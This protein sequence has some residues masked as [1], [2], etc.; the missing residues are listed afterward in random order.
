[1]R[2]QQNAVSARKSLLQLRRDNVANTACANSEPIAPAANATNVEEL[3]IRVPIE[4]CS[5]PMHLQCAI[6]WLGTATGLNS[7]R[8]TLIP[9]G[10]PICRR[11]FFNFAPDARDVMDAYD[12]AEQILN[13]VRNGGNGQLRPRLQTPVP[14]GPRGI[15]DG[16]A[17]RPSVDPTTP[18]PWVV[19][20]TTATWRDV[21][22]RLPHV[23]REA[24][25]FVQAD[26]QLVH[27]R[28]LNAT[29]RRR[30]GLPVST[31]RSRPEREMADRAQDAETREGSNTSEGENALERSNTLE[32]HEVMRRLRPN[33]YLSIH[34]PRRE[35]DALHEAATRPS[36]APS[37]T[38]ARPRRSPATPD[39]FDRALGRSLAI[40]SNALSGTRTRD[41]QDIIESLDRLREQMDDM[42]L[43]MPNALARATPP[44]PSSTRHE[45]N[46]YNA[47]PQP[48]G[49]HPWQQQPHGYEAPRQQP[50]NNAS[51]NP[52]G[53]GA[54]RQQPYGYAPQNPHG[55]EAS[56][57]QPYGYAPQN[58]AY[59]P[60]NHG[61]APPNHGY[62]PPNHGYGAPQQHP[63]GYEAPQQQPNRYS[64]QPSH[65]YEVPQQPYGYAQQY[66][67]GYAPPN[68]GYGAPQ[69]HHH[70]YGA[71]QQH[72]HGYEAPQQ[73]PNHPWQQPPHGYETPRQP[74][75]HGAPPHRGD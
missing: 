33:L 38:S 27:H 21:A 44:S 57:Q 34:A 49:Y 63:Y 72:H 41:V 65:G 74:Y 73:Q 3:G 8:G 68:N 55:Y 18:L 43:R 2:F 5:H 23:A 25:A 70:G 24:N 67:H 75:G 9:H 56:Q 51:Q 59:T 6:S 31:F 39:S 62:A 58:H 53:W 13:N 40:R 12:T 10:C 42:Q 22:D 4:G 32:S 15:H 66:H 50:Y 19:T 45:A 37:A 71:P 61:Y 46:R 29:G 69:Q 52:H 60:Q 26:H 47:P 16:P 7:E 54:P 64:M 14:F 20:P 1:M 48:F 28:T 11:R 36:P 30:Q 17:T 35:D